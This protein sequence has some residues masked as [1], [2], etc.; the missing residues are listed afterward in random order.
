[1]QKC[2]AFSFEHKVL[3]VRKAMICEWIVLKNGS[4]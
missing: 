1:L 2:V 3:F 4:S